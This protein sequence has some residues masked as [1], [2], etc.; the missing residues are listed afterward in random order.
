MKSNGLV[1]TVVIRKRVTGYRVF[2][3]QTDDEGLA[4][5]AA[6]A[7][8]DSVAFRGTYAV[9]TDWNGQM[10]SEC[11]PQGDA[12]VVMVPTP[13]APVVT[14]APAPAPQRLPQASRY[15]APPSPTA[16]Y[17]PA[18][19]QVVRPTYA[20]QPRVPQALPFGTRDAYGPPPT[21]THRMLGPGK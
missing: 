19:V 6:Q 14:G 8:V 2:S 4:R 3:F 10:I 7:L 16:G 13:T 18:P 20:P 1:V 21:P 5:I 15:G 9:L 12:P 11:R 17:G